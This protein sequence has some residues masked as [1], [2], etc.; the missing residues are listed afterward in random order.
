MAAVHVTVTVAAGTYR[1][2]RT[3]SNGDEHHYAGSL[4]SAARLVHSRIRQD[5]GQILMRYYQGE[6]GEER[7]VAVH[8]YGSFDQVPSVTGHYEGVRG[9]ERLVRTYT[10]ANGTT[11]HYEGPRNAERVVRMV[12]GNGD[13]SFLRDDGRVV[14]KVFVSGEIM[15]LGDDERIVR[16]QSPDGTTRFYEGARGAERLVRA[17]ALDGVVEHFAGV[18]GRERCVRVESRS[19]AHSPFTSRRSPLRE[20]MLR[21]TIAKQRSAASRRVRAMR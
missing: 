10:S 9:E 18:Q 1:V 3:R 5:D 16:V 2:C 12:S 17:Q 7:V 14:R 15:V 20:R 8:M 21:S 19:A 6:R 11:C 13:T 4:R